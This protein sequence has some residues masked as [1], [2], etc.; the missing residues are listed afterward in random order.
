M[1]LP[2]RTSLAQ[3]DFREQI[4]FYDLPATIRDRKR[5]VLSIE[6]LEFTKDVKTTDPTVLGS[7][8]LTIFAGSH[9]AITNQHV[10]NSVANNQRLLVGVNLKAG[11]VFIVCTVAAHDTPGDIAVLTLS[12]TIF[13][14]SQVPKDSIAIDQSAAGTSIFADS[15]H[16]DE[17]KG[18]LLI[19]FPLGLGSQSFGNQPV[20]RTGTIAQSLNA[21]GF[22]LIDGIASHGNSGS[23]VFDVQGGRFC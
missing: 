6:A 15:T 18:V 4:T 5:T 20:S 14:K 8:F 12:D 7:G 22:F 2:P 3:T 11:K 13:S 19:G 17:G 16:F 10:I 9:Y 23:P 21:D 1:L